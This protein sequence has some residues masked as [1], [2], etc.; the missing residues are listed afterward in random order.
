MYRVAISKDLTVTTQP[1]PDTIPWSIAISIYGDEKVMETNLAK[2]P[3][4]APA[5]QVLV[6]PGF[7]KVVTAYNDALD[8]CQSDVLVFAHPDVYLPSP[9]AGQLQTALHWLQENDPDWAVL[10]LFGCDSRGSGVGFT[11]SVGLGR[12][13]GTPLAYPVPARTVDEFVFVVRKSSGLRFDENL[14]GPQSQLCAPD[15]CLQAERQGM[16]VYI[17]PAFA[18]H[19]SNGWSILPLKFWKP[20]LF[21][22]KKWVSELPVRLPYAHITKWC[23]P[24]LKNTARSWLKYRK[25]GYR[26]NSRVADVEAHYTRLRESTAAAFSGAGFGIASE[27]VAGRNPSDASNQP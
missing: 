7:D 3:S 17:I 24:L 26:T 21:V 20:Y 16:S 6:Q 12:F 19:N 13:V 15:I 18:L 4:L 10:G 8:K 22:R 25:S 27:L 23:T 5:S 14:P 11:Y 2:S 9:W 1:D